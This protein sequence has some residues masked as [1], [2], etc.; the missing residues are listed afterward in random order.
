MRLFLASVALLAL[1][2]CGGG[3]GSSGGTTPPPV[4]GP[5]PAPPPPPPPPVATA[6]AVVTASGP[7]FFN[8]Y[9]DETFTFDTNAVGG[10]TTRNGEYFPSFSQGFVEAKYGSSGGDLSGRVKLAQMIDPNTGTY[11]RFGAPANAKIVSPLTALLLGGADQAKLK[12]QLGI[13]GSIFGLSINPELLTFDPIAESRSTDPTRQ[14]DA[15]RLLAGN[16]RALALGALIIDDGVTLPIFDYRPLAAALAS[17]PNRFLFNQNA[18]MTSIVAAVPGYGG[19]RPDVQSAIAHLINA[20]AAAIFDRITEA[21]GASTSLMGVIGWLA[22]RISELRTANSATAASAAL[23]ITAPQI[24]DEIARYRERIPITTTGFFFPGPDH[25]RTAVNTPLRLRSGTAT[26]QILRYPLEND[27]NANGS[28][29]IGFFGI[30]GTTIT[31]I[32]VPA[33]N[34]AQVSAT[35]ASDGEITI[36]PLPGFTG[37]TYVDYTVRHGGGEVQNARMYVRVG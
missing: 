36:T 17:G 1:A 25:Y 35:L 3:G 14:L 22:P 6:R 10:Y 16:A 11:L 21:D 4:A 12:T 26:G 37:L 31:A 2:S 32:S 9:P 7:A 15:A 29:V 24:R 19:L 13:T 28:G 23:A 8:F 27:V 5:P 18:E 33:A 34:T 30:S 20:Y